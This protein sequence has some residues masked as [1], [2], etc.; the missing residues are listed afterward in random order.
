MRCFN[1][2]R[3]TSNPK[4]LYY[5]LSANFKL[6]KNMP[7]CT[8]TSLMIKMKK[9]FVKLLPYNPKLLVCSIIHG[10]QS[11]KESKEKPFLPPNMICQHDI[12]S[13]NKKQFFPFFFSAI[14]SPNGNMSTRNLS[15]LGGHWLKVVDLNICFF[16]SPTQP[17][18]H[19]VPLYHHKIVPISYLA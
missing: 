7:N 11:L 9:V 17:N 2:R 1:F 18:T 14:H 15:F 19:N 16:N 10:D 5:A 6:T 13:E 8:I 3:Q 12:P 4:R